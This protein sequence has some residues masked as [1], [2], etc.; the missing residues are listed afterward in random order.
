MK[1]FICKF[2]QYSEEMEEENKGLEIY[3]IARNIEQCRWFCKEIQKHVDFKTKPRFISSYERSLD[4]LN[5]KN[6]FLIQ[7]GEFFRNPIENTDGFR[8]FKENA[9]EFYTMWEI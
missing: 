5:P 1:D 6:A 4:G 2:K 7:C 9:R 8:R 3:I